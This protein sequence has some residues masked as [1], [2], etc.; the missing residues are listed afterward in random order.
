ML[1]AFGGPHD[2]PPRTDARAG[3]QGLQRAD[4]GGRERGG[5]L[6]LPAVPAGGDEGRPA[7]GDQAPPA[8]REHQGQ[9]D[10]QGPRGRPPQPPQAYDG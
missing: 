1:R 8:A 5:G 4:R 10:P 9:E 3:R 6:H 7:P 2:R